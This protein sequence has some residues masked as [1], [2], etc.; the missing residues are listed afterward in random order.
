MK[1]KTNNDNWRKK[2]VPLKP[3]QGFLADTKR[4]FFIDLTKVRHLD[5]ILVKVLK[6]AEGLPGK[7]T[8]SLY[9]FETFIFPVYASIYC[10]FAV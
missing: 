9:V 10:V 7:G 8:N 5:L 6:F 3:T 2:Y 1:G 4:N